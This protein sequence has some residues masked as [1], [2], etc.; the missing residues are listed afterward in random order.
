MLSWLAASSSSYA[1]APR[2]VG[3]RAVLQQLPLSVAALTAAAAVPRAAFADLSDLSIDVE[4]AP[5]AM[6]VA[7]K[8]LEGGNSIPLTMLTN[9][10]REARK[11]NKAQTPGERIKEIQAKGGSATDK[12]KKE[13]KRCVPVR[14]LT[15]TRS[16]RASERARAR[17]PFCPPASCG[18]P[19]QARARHACADGHASND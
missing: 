1:P 6:P 12:E 18:P 17:K 15:T 14:C 5:K 11:K 10:E 16:E 3:R 7:T 4:E 13:L 19:S 2:P 9:E 8:E